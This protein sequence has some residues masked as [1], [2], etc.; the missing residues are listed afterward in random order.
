MSSE[1]STV[2]AA[3]HEASPTIKQFL[4]EAQERCRNRAV[5]EPG[6]LRREIFDHYRRPMDELFRDALHFGGSLSK[7]PS[8][9]DSGVVVTESSLKACYRKLFASLQ[10]EVSRSY[11]QAYNFN[12]KR[13]ARCDDSKLPFKKL[14]YY[15]KACSDF[16]REAADLDPRLAVFRKISFVNDAKDNQLANVTNSNIITQMLSIYITVREIKN[17]DLGQLIIPDDLMHKH[18]GEIIKAVLHD[19]YTK[20]K[21][22]KKTGEKKIPFADDEKMYPGQI[23]FPCLQNWSRRMIDLDRSQHKERKEGFLHPILD[24]PDHL[25]TIDG[26]IALLRSHNE[27]IKAD[28]AASA[29][30]KPPKKSTVTQKKRE[31]KDE[32][33]HEAQKKSGEKSAAELAA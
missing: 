24:N 11:K 29:P 15:N 3:P 27:S 12:P 6:G 31:V 9:K 21:I 16:F 26:E 19:Q 7:R 33:L 32:A 23:R 17:K 18:S 13:R 14:N 5:I 25:K 10:N 1:S 30:P 28:L 8:G 20:E 4:D 2:Q 22:D